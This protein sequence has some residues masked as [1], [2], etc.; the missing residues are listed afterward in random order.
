MARKL[1]VALVDQSGESNVLYTP[2]AA[3]CLK[4]AAGADA[5]LAD[6]EIETLEFTQ[7][8]TSAEIVQAVVAAEPDIVGFSTQGWNFRQ[9]AATFAPIKQFLPAAKLVLGGNHVSDR[10]R[11]LL[12]SHPEIDVVV[13]GE[14]E[15]TFCDL[16][17]AL[18]DDKSLHF[19]SGVTFR[20]GREIVTTQARPR[21]RQLD[22]FPSPYSL[23]DVDYSRYDVALLE[24][25]R[26][27]PYRCAFCYW[28]GRIGQKIARG[29]V[30]RVAEDLEVIGKA[31]IR[32][33]F[34]C[35]ANVGILPE[36]VEIAHL[37][38]AT[39]KRY[40][41][42]ADVN[43]NWA[44]NNASRVEEI[45]DILRSAGISLTINVPMQTLSS[46][47]L[48]TARRTEQGRAAMMGLARKMIAQGD[49]L[50][51][52]LI[53]GMPGESL[54]EFQQNYDTLYATFPVLR[55]HPLWL[56]PNTGYAEDR[57]QLGIRTLSPDPTSD[58]EA[59]VA[60]ADLPLADMR[61]GLAML[62]SHSILSLLGT[63]RNTLRLYARASGHSVAAIVRGFEAFV[64][65]R[66]D[67]LSVGFTQLFTR[68]RKACYFERELRARK[69]E[70][71]YQSRAA[72]HGLVAE[73]LARWSIEP[74]LAPVAEQLLL[75]DCM[76]LP[77]RDLDGEGVV[78]SAHDFSFD[79]VELGLRLVRGDDDWRE[80][81]ATAPPTRLVLE[82]R[83]GL[84]KLDGRNCDLTGLWAGRVKQREP[85]AEP[86]VAVGAWPE[87]RRD[88][89]R[90]ARPQVLA[91]IEGLLRDHESR[92][93]T[94][95]NLVASENLLSPAARRALASD[96]AHRYCIPPADARPAS[97]WDYP[98]QRV[99]RELQRE[100]EELACRVF[101]G[102]VAD[103]R[104]LS[105]AQT[106]S[107]LLSSAVDR[108]ATVASVPAACGGHFGTEAI[109]QAQALRR[110]DLPYDEERGIVDVE[111]AAELCRRTGVELVYLDASMQLFPHPVR[112]L[113]DALGAHVRLV[114]DASH[115]MGL[116]GGGEFQDPLAEG[117]DLLQGST[118][119]SL[120]GPQKGLFVFARDDAF[121]RGVCQRV[122]PLFVSNAHPHAIAA[123]AVALAEVE[124]YG[125][126]YAQQV[127]R[128]ARQLAA[129]LA[130]MGYDILFP[131]HGFTTNHQLI[132]SIGS[133][134][135]TMAAFE[136]LESVGLH[137]NAIRL[138]FRQ[139]VF[140]FR[141]GVAELTR[142]GLRE[143]DLSAVARLLADAFERRRSPTALAAR[144]ADVSLSFPDVH[145]CG[146]TV[147]ASPPL[148]VL[149]PEVAVGQHCA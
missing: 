24:T 69:R 40:G 136:F 51:C 137:T 141:I 28:G 35:D 52:E 83:A 29:N 92:R 15:A 59:V 111:R 143:A 123:L 73:Y 12:P 54:A 53:Y 87:A 39:F 34:L 108:G 2:L 48:A 95:L 27:C 14:G 133:R 142:R 61:D 107:I 56:L 55:I 91:H 44:K 41:A 117:A 81:L 32:T 64:A 88:Q 1:R 118:H 33:I 98:N 26:G 16:L 23:A 43:V 121:A 70:L 57:E 62:L 89:R 30:E 31:G 86:R 97:I 114:Y 66:S 78:P 21:S 60:H 144:V 72:T 138:P 139:D 8:H 149:E 119:K 25:N 84:G 131:Q 75:Y 94:T 135:Q 20:S 10:G 99:V 49:Q 116:I 134:A 18:R 5:R 106:A 9:L 45:I 146:E 22:E 115:T 7:I 100:A 90:A 68:I 132:W 76:L 93:T 109:C 110:V 147:V 128:N 127:V 71:L 85:I 36:D 11:E 79:P 77:R 6:V 112:E 130:A 126:G 129:E 102:E 96:V 38:A 104:P 113:R 105:G 82:H 4:A 63:A 13:D 125:A 148:A 101:G 37:M 67:P 19:V 46:R 80:W 145:F 120:F 65:E 50:Y 74:A 42:P 103:V 122:T 17:V 3:L 124:V 140:G 58:Y 47:A